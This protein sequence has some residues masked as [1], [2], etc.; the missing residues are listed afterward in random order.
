M[1]R[2]SEYQASPL[3][4]FVRNQLINDIYLPVIG[5]NF[6]KQMG[7]VGEHKRSDLMGL[8]MLISPPGY[9]KT[10][11][12]EYVASRLGLVFM[13]INGPSLGHEVRSL[14]PAQTPTPTRARSWKS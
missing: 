8:L 12:M 14:D 13:K 9:G 3:T 5:D 1:L 2:L 7:T 11:L 4:S 6:A 10:T